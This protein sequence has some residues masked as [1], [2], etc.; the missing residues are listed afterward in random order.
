[1][2]V[3]QAPIP[4]MHMMPYNVSVACTNLVAL[5]KKSITGRSERLGQLP[6]DQILR[7]LKVVDLKVT[8]LHWEW[9][10]WEFLGI[11]VTSSQLSD[12]PIWSLLALIS[13][14]EGWWWAPPAQ[15]QSTRLIISALYELKQQK[16]L[17]AVSTGAEL[18]GW[19]LAWKLRGPVWKTSF[20]VYSIYLYNSLY[21]YGILWPCSG[22]RLWCRGV[23]DVRQFTSWCRTHSWNCMRSSISP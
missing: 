14:P 1:M 20:Q 6:W 18:L 8:I 15:D 23:Q 11:G 16:E 12:K 21:N 22:A 2:F 13:I 19:K 17:D 3:R 4:Q 7:L 5:P 10:P 9:N